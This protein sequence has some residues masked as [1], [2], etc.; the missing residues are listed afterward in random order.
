LNDGTE[1][2]V[3]N[4]T[5]STNNST[6]IVKPNLIVREELAYNRVS[7]DFFEATNQSV[8]NSKKKLEFIKEKEREIKNK[9]MSV[10]ALETFVFDTKDKLTQDEFIA[11]STETERENVSAKLSEVT[12]W[13]DEAGFDV[14]AKEYNDQL[15]ALKKVCKDIFYRLNEK[16]SLPQKLGELKEVLNK[17]MNFLETI[18][19]MTGGED[20]PLTQM[21]YTTFAKLIDTTVDWEKKLTAEQAKVA[22]N[23]T[24]KLLSSDVQEKSDNLKREIG[25]L[26]TKI[27]YFRPPVKKPEA[28]TPKTAKKANETVVEQEE[29][30]VKGT[31]NDDS[32][33]TE[34]PVSTS[35]ESTTTEG[36]KTGDATDNPEL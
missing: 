28:K 2:L 35:E 3:A 22:D 5:N 10:N 9:A 19:N 16:K 8:D 1:P 29:E 14:S 21:Q 20:Q 33:K 15:K 36:P 25:Y 24:P 17:S 34:E 11:C 30:T 7:L 18:K 12:E 23:E 27:K 32:E 31:D 6:V 26:V 13:M 4:T